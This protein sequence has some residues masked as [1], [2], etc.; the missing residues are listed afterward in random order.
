MALPC[1]CC[2]FSFAALMR[3][4]K[5]N[6]IVRATIAQYLS[7]VTHRKTTESNTIQKGQC[8]LTKSAVFPLLTEVSGAAGGG[9]AKGLE[10]STGGAG[11]VAAGGLALVISLS[12]RSRSSTLDN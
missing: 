9:T 6:L 10:T 4:C 3:A 1:A 7:C 2:V 12:R 5:A 8:E 11:A